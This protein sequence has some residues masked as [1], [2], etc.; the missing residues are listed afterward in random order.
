MTK[1]KEK[2]EKLKKRFKDAPDV[3]AALDSAFGLG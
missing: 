3:L 1:E 2:L